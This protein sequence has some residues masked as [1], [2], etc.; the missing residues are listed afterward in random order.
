[1]AFANPRYR[2]VKTIL[3]NGLDQQPWEADPPPPL[4]TPY[5]GQGR[6]SRDIRHLFADPAKDSS[7]L[8]SGDLPCNP[9][10][11]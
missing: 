10:L 2:T 4:G 9:C 6:F 1:M 3:E 5:T 7:S 11:N 8:S